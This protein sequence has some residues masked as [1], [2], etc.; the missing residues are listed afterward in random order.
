MIDPTNELRPGV[1]RAPD[2]PS[3]GLPARRRSSATLSGPRSEVQDENALLDPANQSLADALRLTLRI[4]YLAMAVLVVA[5][6]FSGLQTIT[7]GTR[8]LRVIL[9]KIESRNLLPGFQYSAPF[10]FG[11]IIRVETGESKLI[12]DSGS[13][14]WI[15]LSDAEKVQSAD[16]WN[17]RGKIDPRTDGSLITAD[18][19]LAHGRFAVTY[20]RQD[21]DKWATNVIREEE[22]RLVRSAAQRGILQSVAQTN[23]DDLLKQVPGEAG[24]VAARAR[25]IAQRSLD[26]LDAGIFIE[27]LELTQ[28]MPPLDTR[29]KFS[30]LQTAVAQASK[31]REDAAAEARTTL[32]AMAGEAHPALLAMI[33]KYEETLSTGDAKARQAALDAVNAALEGQGDV[34]TKV[35]GEV[36][37]LMSEA[38][39]YRS[40]IVNQRRGELTSYLAKLAQFQSN[41]GVMINRE[42]A[43]ALTAFMSRDSV[44]LFWLPPGLH[45]LQLQTNS[46]PDIL[47]SLEAAQRKARNEAA[48]KERED[49]LFNNRFKTNTGLTAPE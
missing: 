24:S 1:L 34:G 18:G 22:Q 27:K 44:E 26:A 38:R 15:N 45:T 14:Y 33:D 23:I 36:S 11:E 42:W 47:K 28:V 2:E 21:A 29:E 19:N 12:L 13:D 6:L 20:R 43:E 8:G 41:P 7:E 16:K 48:Q 30:A 9:G 32:N 35:S 49:K 46:D 10:P 37:K 25:E 40:Q 31:A 39:Q 5:Y 3:A 17:P 4:I